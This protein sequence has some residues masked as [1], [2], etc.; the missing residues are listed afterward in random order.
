MTSSPFVLKGN[1]IVM[2]LVGGGA[3]PTLTYI[4]FINSKG[5]ELIRVGN[6]NFNGTDKCLE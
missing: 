1:G 5:E 2:F 6:E 3:D 4:S